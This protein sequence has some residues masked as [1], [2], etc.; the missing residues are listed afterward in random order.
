MSEQEAIDRLKRGDLAG[1]KVLVERFQVEAVHAAYLITG[2]RPAAEDVAQAAFL[3]AAERIHQFRDGRPFRPWFLRM[4]TND[5]LKAASRA[6]RHVP[7]DEQAAFSPE[8]WIENFNLGP[9]EALDRAE[10]RDRVW[11]ALQQLAPPQRKAVVMRFFLGMRDREIAEHLGRPLTSIKWWL[12]TAR[13][14]L[15]GLLDP[16]NRLEGPSDREDGPES[17]AGGEA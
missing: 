3:K 15:R 5:A 6:A 11:R 9:E 16:A 2:S 7:Y 12:H 8:V 13:E 4:V 1:L 17:H 10:T 14:R